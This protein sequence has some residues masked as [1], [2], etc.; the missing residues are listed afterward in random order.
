MRRGVSLASVVAM[1]LLVAA[2][3]NAVALSD[4]AEDGETV[5]WRFLS[6]AT[7]DEGIQLTCLTST[8]LRDDPIAVDDPVQ[9]HVRFSCEEGTGTYC[10][11]P[12]WTPEL[13]Q[14]PSFCGDASEVA[15]CEG[16][17]YAFTGTLRITPLAEGTFEVT[18]DGMYDGWE[19]DC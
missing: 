8:D 16:V 6:P 1:L 15:P 4:R 2:A 10:D 19:G 7:P 14:D 5:E 17:L 12:S 9:E 18:Y 13:L 11:Y 3:P